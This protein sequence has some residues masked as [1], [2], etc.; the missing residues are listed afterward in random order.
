[1]AKKLLL[2]ACIVFL[3][4]VPF[5]WL[6]PGQMDLGGDSSRLYFYDPIN[7]LKSFGLFTVLPNGFGVEGSSY[8]M[9]PFTLVFGIIHAILRSSYI[10]I[11]LFNAFTLVV[12][13]LSIYGIVS[14]LLKR[15]KDEGKNV[16][17]SAINFA[18]ITAGLLYIFSP[19][20][21]Q[22]GWWSRALV[23]HNQYFLNPLLF[24]LFLQYL[25]TKRFLYILVILVITFLFAPNFFLSP[26]FFSFYPVAFIFLLLY[27]R[28]VLHSLPSLKP[29]IFAC[30]LF[31]FIHA[32]HILPFVNSIFSQSGY[33]YGDFFNEG[34]LLREG[35][36]YFLSVEQNTR[37]ANNMF[38]LSQVGA[39]PIPLSFFWTV[40]PVLL[41]L[42][43]LF[44]SQ[45][46]ADGGRKIFLLL[47]LFFL[48][49]FF[50][51]S[52][53]ITYT[54]N[55]LYKLFFNLPGSSMFRNF[56]GQFSHLFV[57]FYSLALGN[58]LFYIFSYLGTF[59]KQA[60]LLGALT[61]F[62]VISNAPFIR[63]DGI[64]IPINAGGDKAVLAPMKMDPLFEELLASI[65]EDESD[66]KYLTLPLD[67]I[68][69]Q[70]VTGSD[71][72]AYMGPPLI[73]YLAGKSEFAGSKSL[74]P[75]DNLFM[76]VVFN[77]DYTAIN[78]ILSI[79]N[80]KHIFYNSDPEIFDE[81]F[82]SYPYS[83]VKKF[84]PATQ[85][86]YT[87]FISLLDVEKKQDFGDKLHL[88]KLKKDRYLPHIYTAK[89][90]IRF[91]NQ[92]AGS[93]IKLL[94]ID[95]PDKR[96]AIL[97]EQS[98]F[99]KESIQEFFYQGRRK[100][101]LL[102]Y[103]GKKNDVQEVTSQV[104]QELAISFL[105]ILILRE[106]IQQAGVE[107]AS[108]EQIDAVILPS[109]VVLQTMNENGLQTYQNNMSSLVDSLQSEPDTFYSPTMKKLAV[110]EVLA[111]DKNRVE[112]KIK[113]NKRLLD[114]A[115]ATFQTLEN[116]MGVRIPYLLSTPFLFEN[117]PEATYEVLA[118]KNTIVSDF[119]RFSTLQP[120]LQ[121]S[122][123]NWITFGDV[124]P[125]LTE[126][127]LLQP[128][129]G[130]A[131]DSQLQSA[132]N[133]KESAQYI[134]NVVV[135]GS[136]TA[137][138]QELIN[139][140]SFW[141]PNTTYFLTLEYL[142][143][144]SSPTAKWR[145]YKAIIES[146]EKGTKALVLVL[147]SDG[148]LPFTLADLNNAGSIPMRNLS[149]VRVPNPSV[150]LRNRVNVGEELSTP[151]IR[152]TKIN[153]TKY[154]VDV[155]GATHPYMLVFLEAF[156]RNWKIFIKDEQM[157]DNEQVIET[158]F[159]GQIKEGKNRNTFFDGQTFETLTNTPLTEEGHHLVNGY[160]NGWYIT[161]ADTNGKP[162]Y[163]LIIEMI[164][165]RQLY[166]LLSL[167]VVSVSGCII[168]ICKEYI[169][170]KI[171]K[172]KQAA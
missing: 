51:A 135:S 145:T 5:L 19:M 85:A 156:N 101:G 84:M 23:V 62:I 29:L 170:N 70:V 116:R 168:W 120:S 92:T 77:K 127:F 31:F 162:D 106:K 25:N 150:L 149:I 60:A 22:I 111:K 97:D 71:N 161:P 68:G 104:N 6:K 69:Q 114:I 117:I 166:L 169:W 12:A 42:G 89:D 28:I 49:T 100:S 48:V 91:D 66:A 165:Q 121:Q 95:R 73:S 148:P 105:P 63:G 164:S 2:Y 43:L 125:P 76:D 167:S 90:I 122:E 11:T 65:R 118:E 126:G 40:L 67:D 87:H 123:D 52:A 159:D 99:P 163:T 38:S 30:V 152:F 59:R 132:I 8:Y 10:L 21:T 55:E 53:M 86:L 110:L 24:F 72:G 98:N 15:I 134:A 113:N 93:V 124:K 102:E 157:M 47:T 45:R 36:T 143:A 146:D 27:G 107:S 44:V 80:V 151:S 26:Y 112:N 1:M 131:I 94:S 56:V 79:I 58:A 17:D 153:P 119:V 83:F 18:A 139:Y 75:F 128:E 160:A 14:T 171:R 141:V 137:Y 81:T 3:F 140:V 144:N 34:L 96:V 136:G 13:F 154:Q 16:T 155:R 50:L 57:F 109:Q 108:N 172:K 7:H 33:F 138:I 20:L 103:F 129:E 142:P 64:K 4:L 32:F 82:P 46:Q 88:L 37:I 133:N 41:T 35:L 158:Y 54:S 78:N 130:K 9:I 74:R 61:L 147:N 115:N 39:A